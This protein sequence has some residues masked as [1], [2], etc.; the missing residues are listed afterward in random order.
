MEGANLQESGSASCPLCAIVVQRVKTH[1]D[2]FTKGLKERADAS[3]SGKS[4]C[5]EKLTGLS[6][7]RVSQQ[8]SSHTVQPIHRLRQ[9]RHGSHTS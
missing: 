3:G 4:I 9:A 5:W 6:G 2:V 7:L 1:R 8:G